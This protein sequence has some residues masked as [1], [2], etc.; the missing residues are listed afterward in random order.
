[1]RTTE[2]P[3]LSPWGSIRSFEPVGDEGILRIRTDAGTSYF[4]PRQPNSRIHDA[5]RVPTGW[6]RESDD[7]LHWAIVAITY[8]ALFPDDTVNRAHE[9]QQRA[10]PQR[11]TAVLAAEL[12]GLAGIERSTRTPA[13]RP[14]A[15]QRDNRTD[16]RVMQQ[17]IEKT[18]DHTTDHATEA[19]SGQKPPARRPAWVRKPG[20]VAR[21]VW[22]DWHETVPA[23]HVG[24]VAS[25]DSSPDDE[26]WHLIPADEYEE[27]GS[28]RF[29]V[30]PERHQEWLGHP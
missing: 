24:V 10:H 21:S 15:D 19:M 16:D 30:D 20:P 18:T 6:Y 11:Y 2:L 4:V 25:L 22:G 17:T 14:A 12:A 29:V 13:P 1:M 27:R 9:L 8:P 23:G 26:S 28:F 5:W 3:S 7:D